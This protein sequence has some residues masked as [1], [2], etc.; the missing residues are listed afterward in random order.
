ME[1]VELSVGGH[2]PNDLDHSIDVIGLRRMKAL[3]VR[4]TYSPEEE[5]WLGHDVG[6]RPS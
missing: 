4:K 6:G 5:R 2:L 3:F 1:A